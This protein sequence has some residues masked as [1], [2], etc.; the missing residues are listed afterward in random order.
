MSRI[1]DFVFCHLDFFCCGALFHR[2]CSLRSNCRDSGSRKCRRIGRNGVPGPHI[3]DY[4]GMPINEEDRMRGDTWDAEKW[5]MV[6]HQCQ[7]HPSDYAP[8]GPANLRIWSDT[9]QLTQGIKAWHLTTSWMLSHRVI[10][11]DGRPHPPAYAP[12]T[13]QGFS[14]GEWEGD[15]LK[16]TTTHLREGWVRRNGLAR[17]ER[18]TMIEYLVRHHRFLTLV[19][20]VKDPIYLT[21][22]FIRTS[23][24]VEAEGNETYPN[25][26]IQGVEIEHDKG[27]VAYHLP[28]QNPWL[29]EYADKTGIPY[30]RR[31]AVRKR[32]IRNTRRNWQRWLLP[33]RR[34]HR[35]RA[36][37]E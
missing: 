16:I 18:G 3:G 11:M 1:Y 21:E 32:C 22:P 5:V 14:T 20:I 15:A 31:E 6:E 9:D 29:S 12:H 36:V 19:T 34:H 37:D 33:S 28:G 7:P 25:L 27:W 13:W 30:K 35:R 26:C 2:P 23:D 24:W 4:T 17:S 10:Y 8:R